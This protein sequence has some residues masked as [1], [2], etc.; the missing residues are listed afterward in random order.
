MASQ[1]WAQELVNVAAAGTLYNTFTTA[2]SMLTTATATGMSTGL[3]TLP[4]SFFQLGG[5]L[6]IDWHAAI[7]WA[8]GNTMTLT[9]KV[10]SVSAFVSGAIKVTTT[11]G[12]TEPT[13]GKLLLTCRS[14]GSGTLATLM[15]GGFWTGRGICPIGATAAANYA[16]GMGLAMLQEA[17]PAV[18]TGFD[19]TVANTLDFQI[20]MGTSSASNGFQMHQYSVKSWGNSAA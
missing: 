1:S 14:V 7:S 10:G 4:P 19:S 15:G 5:R 17:A 11:G 9:V 3:I 13:V 16:A 8:S 12:T 2:Q 20:A 18:G 6:E